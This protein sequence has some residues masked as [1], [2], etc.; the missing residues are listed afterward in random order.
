ME[1]QPFRKA[2]PR[3][4]RRGSTRAARVC[5][6]GDGMTGTASLMLSILMLAAFALIGGGGWLLARGG[7]RKRGALMLVAGL[8]LAGNVAILTWPL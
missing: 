5:A 8:V 7:D 4:K 3:G 1:R 2:K 6:V